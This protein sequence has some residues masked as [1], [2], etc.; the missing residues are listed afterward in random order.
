MKLS[1]FETIDRTV[2]ILE[3]MSPHYESVSDKLSAFFEAIMHENQQA[4]VSVN[5]RVKAPKSLREKILRNKLYQKYETPELILDNLPDLIGIMIFCRFVH[6]E[7]DIFQII[8]KFF[9]D[10]DVDGWSYN[11]ELKNMPIYLNLA[12]KQPQKQKNGFSIYRIDGHYY[13]YGEKINFELQVK[14]LVHSFWS[15]IEHEVIYKNNSYML[16]DSFMKDMLNSIHQNLESIDKQIAL[17]Y[18]QMQS[19][20]SSQKDPDKV[21]SEEFSKVILAK[22]INDIFIEKMRENI[23]FTIDF[24]KACDILSQYIFTKNEIVYQNLSSQTMLELLTRIGFISS[25]FIDFETPIYFEHKFKPKS[26]FGEILGNKLIEMINIDFEWNIFFKILFEIEPGNNIDDFVRFLSIIKARYAD[27][28]LYQPIFDKFDSS[29]ASYIKDDIL[30][31]VATALA[32]VGTISMI[33]EEN[34]ISICKKTAGFVILTSES[35]STINEWED[36]KDLELPQFESLI[37]DSLQ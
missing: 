6:E 29:D 21:L 18:N 1:F 13:S 36:F 23:G 10:K 28:D 16:I 34:F 24:K 2:N 14:S 7:K 17:I 4:I 19:V 15:D 8:N 12:E 35:C 27:A 20:S 30:T 9:S 5:R 3:E 22:S 26:R 33:Y 32:T 37:I 31:A 11:P 25:R